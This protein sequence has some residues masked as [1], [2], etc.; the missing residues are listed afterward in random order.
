MRGANITVCVN[1]KNEITLIYKN[2]I[3]EYTIHKK[4]EKLASVIDVKGINHTVNALKLMGEQKVISLR[5]VIHGN[6]MSRLPL[7][8]RQQQAKK[9]DYLRECPYT[10]TKNM[11]SGC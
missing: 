3:L 7:E 1:G 5:T 8:K 10:N 9:D 6:N 2:K 11:R 4:R